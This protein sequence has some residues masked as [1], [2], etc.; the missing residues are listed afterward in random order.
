MSSQIHVF[1][2]ICQSCQKRIHIDKY[3]T[4]V[5]NLDTLS[6][7]CELFYSGQLNRL[8]CPHCNASFTFETP[9]V[10]F[11][12]IHKLACA[13]LPNLDNDGESAIKKP[14]SHIMRDFDFRIVRYQIEALEKFKIRQC[15]CL[16]YVIEYVKLLNF[17]DDTA[18][19]FNEKN[20]IFENKYDN[21]YSFIQTDFNNNILNSYEILCSEINIPE[22]IIYK[23]N[24]LSNNKWLKI[25]RITLKEEILNAK[26]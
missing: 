4:T 8:K 9:M 5:V 22:C 16:D 26:I 18:L 19:P 3:I 15:N 14:P 20:L 23:S 10:I 6:F 1:N 25:D 24:H 13:V 12:Q 2:A 17:D 21:K 7:E 11:S